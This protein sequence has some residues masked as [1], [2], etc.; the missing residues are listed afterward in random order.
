MTILYGVTFPEPIM[1]LPRQIQKGIP[2]AQG[3]DKWPGW[4]ISVDA[5]RVLISQEPVDLN[6]DNVQGVSQAAK[7]EHE[8]NAGCT[9]RKSH[10]AHLAYRLGM[11][12][13]ADETNPYP[14]PSDERTWWHRGR[15]H[16]ALRA[17]L[18]AK[19]AST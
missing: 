1:S 2:G 11:D 7:D 3:W 4:S 16:T 9:H 15:N 5:S 18:A 13:E 6:D 8:A 14:N 17:A 12:S 19:G 10:D